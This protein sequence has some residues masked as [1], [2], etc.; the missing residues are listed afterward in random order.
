M[1]EALLRRAHQVMTRALELEES[2][3]R[4]FVDAECGADA[5]LRAQVQRLLR[6]LSR[7]GDFLETPALG[8]RKRPESPAIPDEIAGYRIVRTIGMG[9][10]ATVYEAMQKKPS[11]RVA[12]KFLRAGFADPSAVQ[13]FQF[14]TEVLARLQHPGI[15]RIYEAGAVTVGPGPP[16]PFFAMEFVEGACPITE[17]VVRHRLPLRER[18]ALFAQVC[19]AVQHGHQLGVIHR[20]LK[21]GN[22]LIDA[23]GHPRVIDF[24]VARSI[25]PAH[26]SITRDA[27]VGQL[28]GTLNYMSPEQGDGSSVDTRSDV[29]SLGVILYELVCGRP[30]YDLSNESIPR[31][32]SRIQEGRVRRPGSIDSRL[33]GDV[34]AI[35]LKAMDRDPARRYATAEALAADLRRHLHCETVEARPPTLSYRCARFVRRHR[36]LLGAAG[37][38]LA[39]IVVGAALSTKFAY[40]TWKESARRKTAEQTAL[41][42]R[43]A[44]RWHAYVASVAAAFSAI[45]A[46]EWAQARARL[47]AAPAEHRGWEWRYLNALTQSTDRV[48]AIQDEMIYA[49][50]MDS[51]G[52]VLATGAADGTLRL[53][54]VETGATLSVA[55]DISGDQIDAIDF[56]RDG[57]TL[58]GGAADGS[59]RLWS[60]PDGRLRCVLGQHSRG[61][62]G[63]SFAPDGR[64]ASASADGA[65]HLWDSASGERIGTLPRQPGGIHGVRFS[66]D[67]SRLA[68]W[69]RTGS[70]LILDSAGTQELHRLSLDAR[71][72]FASFSPSGALLAAGGAEGRLRL[73]DA[74]TGELLSD[75]TDPASL[76]TI[77]CVAFSPDEQTLAIGQNDRR[78]T[79][80]RVA[81]QQPHRRLT[82]HEEA[83]T[84]LNFAPD[85]HRLVT[86]SWDRSIRVWWLDDLERRGPTFEL[87]GHSD[88]LLGVAFSPDGS[89]VATAGRDGKAVLWDSDTGEWI[90]DLIGHSDAVRTVAFSPDA[91]RIATG[92]SD[93]TVRLWNART[94]AAERILSGHRQSV[95]SVVFSPDS[96]SIVSGGEDGIL[97]VWSIDAGE[98]V[99][100]FAGHEARVTQAAISPDG[101]WIASASR[102]RTARVWDAATGAERHVLRGHESDVFAVLYDW[103]G[104]RIFTGS[105]D[106]SVRVWDA[107]SGE[108]LRTLRGHGQF[109]TAL[110]MHPDGSR[111]ASAS[112]FG[113]TV[114]WDV[115]TFD[116]VAS[117]KGSLR[118]ARGIAFSP[119]G[120]RLA[121]TS[122]DGALRLYDATPADPDSPQ[123]QRAA[124]R[125]GAAVRFVDRIL[126][127]TPD[128]DDVARMIEHRADLDDT[129]RAEAFKRL[130]ARS[131]RRSNR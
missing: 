66:L 26:A 89:V 14:E 76:S 122:Y 100:E 128:P 44:A 71:V 15:A 85:G 58:C 114:L 106:Q 41:A 47:A 94:G 127:S 93:A 18:I 43:D 105:R 75:L 109:V 27:G 74:A 113:E 52:S 35:V 87:R 130:L 69:N 92:S 53:W 22:V 104:T 38:A 91:R 29:Y 88:F 16:L 54:S 40:D 17:Y 19:D 117:F 73:W 68:A 65:A 108:C 12:L 78:V 84:G 5:P 102:D 123:A 98:I 86:T 9:G 110:T 124:D 3:R 126:D 90:G 120:R 32:L 51:T 64:V 59:L 129:T 103:T 50:A 96:K 20:D 112:W 46:D 79:L 62:T 48:F 63:V 70:V 7:C 11:R 72:E 115:S 36:V 119:D 125:R 33:R 4:A 67:G 10:M 111:L 34:D 31:A 60:V 101:R 95:W 28:V 107:E 57:R 81:A 49:S 39:A 97:R 118:P 6:A 99:Q 55:E 131:L 23:V 21:P 13:R 8:E 77:R 121:V 83:I 25:D 30:P 82:G 116:L 42:E 37:V 45:R 1:D 2:Q 61:V 80:F 24:G 56:S